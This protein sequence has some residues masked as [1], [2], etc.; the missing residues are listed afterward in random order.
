MKQ[1]KESKRSYRKYD[2]NFRSGALEQVRLGRSVREVA[3]GLGI[4][5]ALLYKWKTEASGKKNES[6]AEIK[7]LKKQLK[8]MQMD[9][10]ILKKALTIFSQSG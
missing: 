9:N 4:S 3:M 8:Q 5:E 6:N 10:D 2:D 1:K 7:E